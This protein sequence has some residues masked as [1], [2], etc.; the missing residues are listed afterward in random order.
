MTSQRLLRVYGVLTLLSTF[1]SSFIWGINTLFLLDAGL[2]VTQA[3]AANAFYTAGEVL[4]EVPTGVV[5]DTWGR[6]ASYLLGAATLFGSTLLYLLMWRLHG[7]FWG[8]AVSSVLL[9]LGFTFFSGATEA[10]LVDGLRATGYAGTL[11]AAFARGQL[12][13]GAGM[14]TGTIAGGV[15]AQATSLGVPYLLRAATLALTF[16]VAF[17]WMRDVGFAPRRVGSWRAEL[18]A[19]ARASID[20]GLRRPPVRWM[21]LGGVFSSGVLI[22]A[23]YAVQPWLLELRGRNDYSLA[24]LAAALAAAAQILSAFLV[25]HARRLFRR[26]TSA[27]LAEVVASAVA[28]VAMAAA[29]RVWVVLAVLFAWALI[30]FAAMP[31]RQAFLNELIPSEQRATVLSSDNLL[32]SFGGALAQPGLGRVAELW[33]YPTS[34]AATAAL[35]LCALPF[36]LLARR[37]RAPSDPIPVARPAHASPGEPQAAQR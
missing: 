26:R 27:L 1:A 5:A 2:T 17:A 25:P 10:W 34:F 24:G 3:F 6:R 11:D 19:V 20:Q 29:T 18:V 15:I 13:N 30:F 9:G 28:L 33:G 8:W 37:T 31:I 12:A 23:F 35:E 7:P 16:A 21:M 14:L 22:Y 36:L 4:F 32:A